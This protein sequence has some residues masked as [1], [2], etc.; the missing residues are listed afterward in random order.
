VLGGRSFSGFETTRRRKDGSAIEIS[1]SNA[2]VRDAFGNVRGVVA[3]DTDITERRRAERAL[4]EARDEFQALI[5]A[6]PVP[7]VAYDREGIVM[8]WNPAAERVFGWSAEEALGRFLPIVPEHMREEFDRLR[9]AVLGGRSFS[10]FETTRRRKDGSAIEISVSNAPVRDAFGNVR[11]VVALDTDITER[12][13]A[14]RAIR[15]SEEK[16]R[17]ALE[18]AAVGWWDWNVATGEV[19]W[20]DNLEPIHGLPPGGFA[21]TFEGYLEHIHPDDREVFQEAVGRAISEASELDF[22]FRVIWPDASVHWMQ[23]IGHVLPDENSK[24]VRMIGLGRDV[25]E[26]K[27][28]EEAL[29]FLAEASE[30]LSRSLDYERTLREVARLAV[31]RLA[32]CCVV[33]MIEE[34]RSVHQLA[35]A[36][37][38]PDMEQLVRDLEQRYPTDPELATSPMGRALRTGQAELVSS[39]S[40]ELLAEYARDEEHAAGLRQLRLASAMFVPLTARGRTS[41]VMAF[42]ASSGRRYTP[43]D[44]SLAKDLAR[45]A[46][47]AVDNARLYRQRSRVARTL[48]RSLLP[49]ELPVIPGVEVAARY[50]AAGEGLEVG[51]DFY[52]LFEAEQRDWAVVIGD[53]C[54]KGV[55]AAAVTGLARHTIRAASMGEQSP[56]GVLR[57]LNDAVLRQYSQGTFCTVIYARLAEAATGRRAVLASGGHPLPFLLSAEG[58][59]RI[60]GTNGSLLGVFPDPELED[61]EIELDPGDVLVL[62]TDGL[63]EHYDQS[64]AAGE[65]R[66][67]EILGESAG[68]GAEEIAG[69][70]ERSIQ[71][72]G[73]GSARDDIAF[74]VLRVLPA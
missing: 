52:D 45:T 66:L 27:Q 23:G 9:E 42:L 22:E 73:S 74:V 14:E 5:E 29:A 15:E 35:V 57:A 51:G 59:T 67:A 16:L 17:L 47:L 6:S 69:K 43:S 46:A 3:L 39:L 68:L 71:D 8:L 44:L 36:H 19:L 4:R 64:L 40:D 38:D 62:Y 55:D 61:S 56:S 37:V 63:V 26:R 10:G 13:R 72:I 34:E 7:I 12:R 65:K 21:G 53:V 30:A 50:Q 33:D 58:E 32:D 20:S 28:R 70:I 31:P 11:G 54:G 41:G 49:P 24:P 1:V 48:Q 60:V 18:A 2:P 25:T